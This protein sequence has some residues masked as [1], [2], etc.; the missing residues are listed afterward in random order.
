MRLT[1]RPCGIAFSQSEV[2]AAART[3]LLPWYM[4][5]YLRSVEYYQSIKNGHGRCSDRCH[6]YQCRVW[7]HIQWKQ[8]NFDEVNS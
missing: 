7:D 2:W 1:C 4:H 3:I 8:V 6:C 5:M